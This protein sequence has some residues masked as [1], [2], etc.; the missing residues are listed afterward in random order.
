MDDAS[1]P[2]NRADLVAMANS[3]VEVLY[4]PDAIEEWEFQTRIGATRPEVEALPRRVKQLLG[5]LPAR[6]IQ[7]R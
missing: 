7:Q 3:L 1:P 5:D 2:F 4:G 6:D